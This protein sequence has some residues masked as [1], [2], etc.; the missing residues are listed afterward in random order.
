MTSLGGKA[1][2]ITADT[3]SFSTATFMVPA[4]AECRVLAEAAG[5]ADFEIYAGVVGPAGD[6]VP[7]RLEHDVTCCRDPRSVR[8][9]SKKTWSTNPP[10]PF[11]PEKGAFFLCFFLGGG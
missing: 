3:S 2:T 5:G 8:P 9:S 7:N 10:T 11:P 4:G 1:I 6:S